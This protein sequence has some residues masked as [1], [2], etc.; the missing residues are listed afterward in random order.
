MAVQLQTKL[1]QASHGPVQEVFAAF[2]LGNWAPVQLGVF[3]SCVLG[4]FVTAVSAITS[5]F[6]L[7]SQ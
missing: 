7:T 5:S 6:A 2:N 1:I 4:L 3:G